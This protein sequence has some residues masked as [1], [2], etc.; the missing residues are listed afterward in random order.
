MVMSDLL[1]V[2]CIVVGYQCEAP[3]PA[4]AIPRNFPP[5]VQPLQGNSPAPSRNNTCDD[6]RIDCVGP[7][8]PAQ[9]SHHE[10]RHAVVID[11]PNLLGQRKFGEL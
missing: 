2:E 7:L 6:L 5:E 4:L 9:N 11:Q 1:E 3:D 10:H 8:K